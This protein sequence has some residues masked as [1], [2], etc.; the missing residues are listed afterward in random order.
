[1]QR[2]GSRNPLKSELVY[3]Q[4]VSDVFNSAEGQRLLANVTGDLEFIKT[5]RP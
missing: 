1:M 2:H 5:V 4:N 3:V